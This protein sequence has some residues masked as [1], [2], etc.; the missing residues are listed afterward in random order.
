MTPVLD[1][2][3]IRDAYLERNLLLQEAALTRLVMKSQNH[4]LSHI[5]SRFKTKLVRIWKSEED[6]FL[7]LVHAHPHLTPEQPKLLES[8]YPQLDALTKLYDGVIDEATMR[9]AFGDEYHDIFTAG[10]NGVFDSF[11]LQFGSKIPNR[12]PISWIQNHTARLTEKWGAQVTATQRERIY[13]ALEGC[14][15]RQATYNE[16]LATIRSVYVQAPENAQVVV[17]TESRKAYGGSE[18]AANKALGLG[19]KSWILSGSPYCYIDVCADN[20]AL[21]DIGIDETFYDMDG[22]EI[23]AA[24]AH[25]NCM[26]SV[27]YAMDELDRT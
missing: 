11:A 20:A 7:A 10:W 5:E 13:T 17:R 6:K 22:E 26:C 25:P 8:R 18:F 21:G 27:G 9:K 15:E 19:L 14:Y 1:L 16:M 12:L 23:D 2:P 24:P 4:L 3:R